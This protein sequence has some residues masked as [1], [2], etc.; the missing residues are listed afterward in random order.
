MQRRG[1]AA[2]RRYPAQGQ[3]EKQA[4]VLRQDALQSPSPYRAGIRTH[5]TVQARRPTLRK[6]SSKFPVHRQF[7][8]RPMLDQIRP[9]GLAT[10]QLSAVTSL[11]VLRHKLT[12]EQAQIDPHKGRSATI[13]ET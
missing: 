10:K 4:E 12:S 13:H 8:C 1:R 7:R 9:H 6:D 3:R 5:Q 2:L 11:A